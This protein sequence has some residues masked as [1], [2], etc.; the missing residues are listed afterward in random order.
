MAVVQSSYSATMAAAVAGMVANQRE[1]CIDSRVVETAAGIG[2]G[3][4]VGQGSADNGAV[5]G[6]S[7]A[8]G[9]VGIS[10]REIT[11][12]PASVDKYSQYGNMPVLTE[13]DIWVTTG[14]IVAAGGD[15]TFNKTTGVLSS[16]AADTN[17]FAITG[18][19]WMTSAASGA[20]AVVRLT[21]AMPSA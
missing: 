10:A 15:V 20:L 11:T 4:V 16:A 7:A 19:R 6:A 18:A 2:F 3:V 8:T 9:F 12:D 5:L 17:N 1:N 14:G 13:G 21:G